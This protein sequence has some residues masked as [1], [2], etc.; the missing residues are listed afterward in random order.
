MARRHL[1]HDAGFEDIPHIQRMNRKY[2]FSL[3]WTKPKPLVERRNCLGVAERLDFHGRTLIPLTD[4][5]ARGSR[6]ARGRAA[7]EYPQGDVA[8]AVCLLFSYVNPA[9]ELRLR[10][11]LAQRF[12]DV[13]ISLSHE[14]APIWRSTSEE[15]GH[16]RRLREADHA[17]LHRGAF[18]AFARAGLDAPWSLMKSNG[19]KTRPSRRRPNR[20]SSCSRGWPAAS[21][22]GSISA[23]SRARA[24]S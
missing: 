22:P 9:H 24:M 17:A 12:P 6:P 7:A 19:G 3:K 11:F 15:H 1:R 18:A 10:E 2:H 13:P 14:V 20:S 23:S 8:I 4:D 21:S 5:G 16:R